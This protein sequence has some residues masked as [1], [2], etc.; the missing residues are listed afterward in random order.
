MLPTPSPRP[1]PTLSV[2]AR[3]AAVNEAQAARF[4]R[5]GISAVAA[6][7]AVTGPKRP[8]ARTDLPA[9]LRSDAND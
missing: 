8:A 7:A 3:R 5:I 9:V 6:A 4:G 1:R 2:A